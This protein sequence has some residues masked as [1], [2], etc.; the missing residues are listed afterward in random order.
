MHSTNSG[1]AVDRARR[2]P[3]AIA[4]AT[5][6]FV[7]GLAESTKRYGLPYSYI[8][9]ERGRGIIASLAGVQGGVL[10]TLRAAVGGGR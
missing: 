9:V 2:G 3:P 10:A 1:G 4:F 6:P 8:G 5:R 7:A